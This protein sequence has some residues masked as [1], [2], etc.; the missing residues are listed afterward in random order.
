MSLDIN[1][2]IMIAILL[3][4]VVI[5]AGLV[6]LS[7]K[8]ASVNI[9]DKEELEDLEVSDEYLIEDENL[10][11]NSDDLDKEVKTNPFKN[12]LNKIVPIVLIL[13]IVFALFF[14]YRGYSAGKD[15]DEDVIDLAAI[16][17]EFEDYLDKNEKDFT[18]VV[19]YGDDYNFTYNTSM[20]KLLNEEDTVVDVSKVGQHTF[21][22]KF[23]DNYDVPREIEYKV[24]IEDNYPPEI[25]GVKNIHLEY[26]EP[27]LQSKL[28]IKAEDVIDGPV[29]VK[30][31][32]EI[33][34]LVAGAYEVDAVAVD[35]NNVMAR[36]PFV[37]VV[38]ERDNSR[39][40]QIEGEKQEVEPGDGITPPT[41][42]SQLLSIKEVAQLV[43]RGD[44]GNY[45]T[46]QQKLEAEGYNYQEVQNEV[47]KYYGY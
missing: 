46:R 9:D 8:G 2:I 19:E 21:T 11:E 43:I 1:Y 6:A 34:T 4:T 22:A 38:A 20:L 14:G 36:E 17:A 30:I 40:V 33:N 18:T 31:E 41:D 44:Y 32:G 39:P 13:G 3:A 5:V 37:V 42:N 12:N 28:D 35:K 29:G 47:N 10:E 23:I 15:T 7:K 24:I 27:F 45:P 25:T 16:Q 26:G